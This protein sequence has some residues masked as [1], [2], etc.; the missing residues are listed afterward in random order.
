VNLQTA[1]ER[2]A[3]ATGQGVRFC[4]MREKSTFGGP[5]ARNCTEQY[6]MFSLSI[7]PQNPKTPKP[8][9]LIENLVNLKYDSICCKFLI[10]SKHSILPL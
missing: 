2:L 10:A 3:F 4:A 6:V 1:I 9:E 8:A 7:A 5:H